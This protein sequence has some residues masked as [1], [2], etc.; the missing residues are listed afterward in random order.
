MLDLVYCYDTTRLTRF[1]GS[2]VCSYGWFSSLFLKSIWVKLRVLQRKH[3]NLATRLNERR[4]WRHHNAVTAVQRRCQ[5]SVL[6]LATVQTFLRQRTMKRPNTSAP[7]SGNSSS[8]NYRSYQ[9]GGS[10]QYQ[11]SVHYAAD[12]TTVLE[13]STKAYYQAD[14]TAAA[15]LQSMTAQKQQINGASSNVWDMRQATEKAKRELQSLHT[16]YRI[17]KQRLYVTIALLGSIDMLLVF[18]IFQCR[19]NFFC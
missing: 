5:F 2:H 7:P 18:R 13:D 19:G 15:V 17:K 6:F 14:E 4:C 16:K 1:V 11:P 8:S 10:Q 9:Q 3:G 12:Q